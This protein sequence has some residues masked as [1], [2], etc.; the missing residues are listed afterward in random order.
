M[1]RRISSCV[2]LLC[3]LGVSVAEDE[4]DGNGKASGDDE[5]TIGIFNASVDEAQLRGILKTKPTSIHLH[6][7]RLVS[8]MAWP[9]DLESL[10]LSYSHLENQK[11]PPLGRLKLLSLGTE[12]SNSRLDDASINSLKE[13][14][15]AQSVLEHV[16]L[17]P[18]PDPLLQLTHV[19][20]LTSLL[21]ETKA[22]K[23]LRRLEVG[24][25]RIKIIKE[26][27]INEKPELLRL[28]HQGTRLF[29]T[30]PHGGAG[31][32]RRLGLLHDTR[33]AV[34]E[35]SGKADPQQPQIEH[36]VHRTAQPVQDQ[37]PSGLLAPL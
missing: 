25:L 1:N 34:R 35:E 8:P 3:S 10:N 27:A 33:R 14:F 17:W 31:H 29:W 23:T 7:F 21:S 15:K 26:A 2:L 13:A 20:F 32:R 19:R 28:R 37:A 9:G 5:A 30:D 18:H 4:T 24:G 22:G 11:F 36:L 16:E 12:W 6:F